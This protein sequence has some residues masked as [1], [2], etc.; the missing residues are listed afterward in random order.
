M[1]GGRAGAVEK[2]RHF[3]QEAARLWPDGKLAMVDDLVLR[4][5][6]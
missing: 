5:L 2:A 6:F 1:V 4:V 3:V